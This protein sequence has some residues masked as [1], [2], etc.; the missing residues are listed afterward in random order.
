MPEPQREERDDKFGRVSHCR[1]QNSPERRA[2]ASSQV[3]RSFAEHACQRNN[4]CRGRH[5]RDQRLCVS[6]VRCK[7]EGNNQQQHVQPGVLCCE[8]GN[9]ATGGRGR[10]AVA[11]SCA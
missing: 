4:R 8:E 2:Y 6:E 7:R 3:F 5:E 1:V 9:G 11:R 10:R